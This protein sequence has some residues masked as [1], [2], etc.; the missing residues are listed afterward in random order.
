[1]IAFYWVLICLL[2]A[3][4]VAGLLR[5]AKGPTPSDRISATLLLGTTGTSVLLLLHA[6]LEMPALLDAALVLVLL[7]VVTAVAFSRFTGTAVKND[8]KGASY[9]A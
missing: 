4:L 5:L 1:M 3:F 9:V 7:A 8:A 2:S 6:V